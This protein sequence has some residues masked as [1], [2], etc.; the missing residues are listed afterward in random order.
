MKTKSI[1]LSLIAILS[2]CGEL[3]STATLTFDS[4]T[5]GTIADSAGLGTGFTSR[6]P[7]TGL[8]L[9]LNDSNMHLLTGSG[10]LILQSTHSDINHS[11]NLGQL[12]APGFF[13]PGVAGQDVSISAVFRDVRVP[14]GSD[15]LN[16][17][18]GTSATS[19]VRAG[20][21]ELQVY[22]INEDQGAGDVRTF[23]SPF[24]SFTPGDDIQ[25]T[26]GRTAGLW[27]LTWQNLTAP[28]ASGTSPSISIPWLDAASDLYAGVIASDAGTPTTFTAKIDSIT[29]IPEP[30]CAALLL[31]GIVFYL[32]R[33]S[34]RMR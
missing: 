34:L 28:S 32:R 12:E 22:L 15:Q 9:P 7:G 20:F 4:A 31:T 23:L 18:F 24:D 10:L 13:L 25:L 11:E 30:S 8:S 16:L 2:V 26:F 17:Y 1:L 14:N 3:T 27:Q 29:V 21:H 6:L 5:P 19:V 33:H